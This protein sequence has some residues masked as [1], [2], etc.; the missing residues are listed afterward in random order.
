MGASQAVIDALKAVTKRP[1]EEG[2]DE[3]YQAF[4]ARAGANLI[5]RKVKMADLLDNL[6]VTRLGEINKK[7]SQR[8]SK[9]LRA[10]RYLE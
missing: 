7:D 6:D 1:D 2:S 3:G 5:A 4:V 10:L 9:Y 8:I